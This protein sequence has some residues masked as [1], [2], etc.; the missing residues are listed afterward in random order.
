M[1]LWLGTLNLTSSRLVFQYAA[2]RRLVN[3]N[4]SQ[5][6]SVKPCRL[7][8]TER[9]MCVTTQAGQSYKFYAGGDEI[10]AFHKQVEKVLGPW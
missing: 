3:F 10:K 4:K 5:I 1:K 8:L 7:L 9:A 6:K 2:D